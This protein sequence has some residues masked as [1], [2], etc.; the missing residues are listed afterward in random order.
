MT[1]PVTI[2]VLC[3]GNSAR[4]ILAEALFNAL[5]EGRVRA[6]SAGSQP[7]GEPH[8]L[9]IALLAGKGHDTAGLR[10]KSWNEFAGPDAP[11]MDIIVTVCD[12]AAGEAC[13]YWPGHPVTGH[14]GIHDPAAVEGSD[15][16]RR[17]AFEAAYRLLELRIRAFL[18]GPID[19]DDPAALNARLKAIGRL[20]GATEASLGSAP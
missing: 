6:F 3:T 18:D 11:T 17:S 1:D 12:S 20:E 8:P 10:S 9:A 19:L 16:A 5:G 13:P 14:W 2:L 15:D 4:S 7:K